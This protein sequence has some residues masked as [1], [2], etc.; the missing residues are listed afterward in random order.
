TK[1]YGL[2]IQTLSNKAH[3]R[4]LRKAAD[5]VS[6][7]QRN[8]FILLSLIFIYVTKSMNILINLVVHQNYTV[9]EAAKAMG[10][11]QSTI[12]K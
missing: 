5:F 1:F 11:G 6:L 2:T 4:L 9:V 12:D 8:N 3:H 7:H 10:V